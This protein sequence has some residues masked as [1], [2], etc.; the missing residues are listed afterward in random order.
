MQRRLNGAGKASKKA[1]WALNKS[2][3]SSKEAVRAYE[4]ARNVWG[5]LEKGFPKR[6]QNEKN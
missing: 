5:G 4:W 2:G 6:R 1:G 3:R